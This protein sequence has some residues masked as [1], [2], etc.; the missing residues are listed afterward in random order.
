MLKVYNLNFRVFI[1]Y[2]NYNIFKYLTD[3]YDRV[4]EV[5]L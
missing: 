2:D 4:L 3:L 1:K 5:Y